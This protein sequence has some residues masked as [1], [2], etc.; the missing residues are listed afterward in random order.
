MRSL[1][2]VSVGL[3]VGV[4]MLFTL[5]ATVSTW[6]T[7]PRPADAATRFGV[8]V[9]VA[10]STNPETTVV[11]NNRNRP[12]TIR[13]FGSIYQPR[14]NEPII[15]NNRILR[16][17]RSVRFESGNAADMNGLPRQFIYN[18]DVGTREGARVRTSVGTIGDRC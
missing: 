1:T 17:D 7:S 15:V 2:F 5:L 10:C 14:P 4:L 3:I 8:T 11:R 13:S 16:P 6:G 18:N 12:I 9:T